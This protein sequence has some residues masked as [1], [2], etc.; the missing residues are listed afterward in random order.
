MR[1]VWS[2]GYTI[3]HP[4]M[5]VVTYIIIMSLNTTFFSVCPGGT[6]AGTN[7]AASTIAVPMMVLTGLIAAL[8]SLF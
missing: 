6:S 8:A 5:V 3:D 4:C 7:D 1:M 2:G